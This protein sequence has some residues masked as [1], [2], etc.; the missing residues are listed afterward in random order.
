MVQGNTYHQ[1][2]LV[3]DGNQVYES[4][5]GTITFRGSNNLN[6]MNVTIPNPYIQNKSLLLKKVKL[7]L[8][9]GGEDSV[10]IF[11]G[12]IN[13]VNVNQDSVSLTC[14]D[15][16]LFLTGK[17]GEKV[18]IDDINNYDG[19]SL[20]GFLYSFIEN[21]LNT[22]TNKVIGI[23]MLNDTN[24]IV[25]CTGI[26]EKGTVYDI[27]KNIISKAIDT[28]TN[29]E[30]PLTYQFDIVEDYDVAQ[31]IIRK[32][33]LLTDKPSTT[34]SY[35]D[36]L[37]SYNYSRRTPP[38][39]SNYE[40]GTFTYTNTPSGKSSI[41]IST[42]NKDLSRADIRNIAMQQVLLEHQEK[43]ELKVT[44][45]KAFHIGIGSIIR[46]S[47]DDSDVAGNHRVVGKNVIFGKNCQCTLTL[48]KKSVKVSDFV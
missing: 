47:V 32:D 7:F 11:S 34:F 42:S 9:N 27:A 23:D 41:D 14:Q 5:S 48:N 37:I 1:P 33:K 35:N 6:S 22:S 20:A 38:N 16:R 31:L 28:D 24:P 18:V 26:R 46:L 40:G 2:K 45:N 21:N 36:G 19:Y 30:T 3:I 15:P 25:S 44:V 39:T 10:P 8:N 17:N 13:S 29:F 12:Y 43:D 4:I